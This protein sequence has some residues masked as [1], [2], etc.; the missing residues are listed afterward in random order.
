ME[1]NNEI[2]TIIENVPRKRRK[3]IHR[4]VEEIKELKSFSIGTEPKTLVL[5]K[6]NL[7]L[8]KYVS[9]Q[10][11]IAIIEA[12]QENK[13]QLCIEMI[14]EILQMPKY[15]QL[16]EENIIKLLDILGNSYLK[17]N[18]HKQATKYLKIV[19]ELNKTHQFEDKYNYE[20]TLKE[21]SKETSTKE[22][23][24]ITENKTTPL[25]IQTQ[26]VSQQL[27]R[28]PI[29]ITPP[30]TTIKKETKPLNNNST[31]NLQDNN[32]STTLTSEEE[33]QKRILIEKTEN[34]A[35]LIQSDK[36]SLKVAQVQ[37]NLTEEEIHLIKLIY[38]R[39]YY[40]EGMMTL[41]DDLL[42]DVDKKK[43]K[44]KIVKEF[45]N[46]IRR[47]RL[48]YKNRQELSSKTKGRKKENTR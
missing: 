19:T 2:V 14:T 30:I 27:Q 16:S 13:Y 26:A 7:E 21:L 12:Y 22:S 38:A 18:N 4:A 40:I 28:E 11:I 3:I 1:T 24:T 5:R 9:K 41:G 37:Y 8:D 35:Y 17:L 32:R 20:T 23:R 6:I 42:K 15:E 47:D 46:E 48:F 45:L 34:L 31:I 25:E 29:K 43:N 10:K 33:E 36:I 44:S 39:D